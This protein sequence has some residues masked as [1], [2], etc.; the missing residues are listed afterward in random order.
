MAMPDI[1]P[2]T[3]FTVAV[4]A[5]GRHDQLA[6]SLQQRGA[7]VVATP[8]LRVV[9]LADD[10]ELRLA[11]L[12]CIARPLDAVVATAGIGLRSWLDAAEGWGLADSLRS[13]LAASYLVV[14]GPTARTAG[15]AG[16][17][18]PASDSDDEVLDH[19]LDTGVA[20]KRIAL[21]LH[22]EPQP[23]F[24]AALRDAG[25]D[26]VEVPVYRW[27]PPVDPAPVRRLVDLTTNRLVDAVAFTSA[28]AVGALLRAA[29][30]DADAILHALRTDVVAA[31]LG[32]LTAAPLR[33]HRVPVTQPPRARIAALV[34][35][36]ADE[37]PRRSRTLCIAGT[38]VTLRG[39]A[40]VVD[41]TLRP[42]AP[43]PMAVLRALA[44]RP[45]RVLS[46]A[47]LL[48]ALP[49][50]ADEHAVEMAVA[51]LRAGLGCAGY[52]QTVVKRGYRLRV[53]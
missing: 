33:R 44:D 12:A 17:W 47:A 53:D 8:V 11:T 46:R 2:L 45:G 6:A 40:A 48:R 19:L 29:G 23:E 1:R 41:G 9:P 27:A 15:F 36:L 37:L 49:R 18:S 3:G 24:G 26:V 35:V 42:L 10:T 7:R 22:T 34:R 31:C 13:R 25:A 32:P 30:T 50:G 16:T 20:G 38:P 39:Y 14:R 51:R 5:D 4:T 21:Q 43:A 28:P 52:V